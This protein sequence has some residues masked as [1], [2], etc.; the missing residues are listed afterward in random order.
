MSRR[1]LL[2]SPR[3]E[4]TG[5]GRLSERSYE[6][7]DECAFVSEKLAGSSLGW[8]H[9]SYNPFIH[10]RAALIREGFTL[11]RLTTPFAGTAYLPTPRLASVWTFA[12]PL[13]RFAEATVNEELTGWIA[14]FSA[15]I[16][17]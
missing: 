16:W 7:I 6:N 5:R 4:E 13:K 17:R 15:P 9:P 14:A 8:R 11:L 10:N 12:K 1:S 2:A 3:K